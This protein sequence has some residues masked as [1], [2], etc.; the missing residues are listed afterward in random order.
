VAQSLDVALGAGEKQALAER[1][2]ANLAA[3]DAYLKGEE[4]SKSLAE[5]DPVSL[6]RAV[7]Y[8]DQAIALDSTFAIAWA[9]R[10][11][12]YSTLYA[13]GVPDPKVARMALASAERARALAPDRPEG[14]LALAV[15]YRGVANDGGP[16]FEQAQLGLKVAPANVDLLVVAALA[17]Q[18]QGRW[19]AASEL[20]ARAQA[21]DPRS[22][23]TAWRLARTLLFRRRYDEALAA[24]ER[25]LQ[26]APTHLG[27][28][29][30]RGMIAAAR[31]DLAAAREAFQRASAAVEPATFVAY[32]ANFY[33]LFWLLDESQRTLLYQL[34]PA[35]FDDD[36]GAWGLSLAGAYALQGD[37]RQARAHADSARAAFE[38]QIRSAPADG[39]LHVLL[40]V[41]LAY[42]G[43]KA[44]AVREGQRGVELSPISRNAFQAPYIQHQLARIYILVGEPD[45]ALDQIEELLK[46]PYYLSPGWLRIDPAFDPLRKLPRFQKLAEGSA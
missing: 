32:A 24:C 39:Q 33:D 22:S 36:R 43:R 6:R 8:Y 37:V 21:I 18:G 4:M 19:E 27:L 35:Q 42:L 12:A 26:I 30:S 31:G 34:N 44:D 20:L 45:K 25:G 15:Y 5:A 23:S 28:L 9:Q 17:Q 13:N 2:T 1:P 7:V 41:A 11:R 14:Y 29:E 38:E 46:I 3:Y 16:A 10:A 40:G